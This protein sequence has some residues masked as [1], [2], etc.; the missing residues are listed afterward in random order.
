MRKVPE[1]STPIINKILE[2]LAVMRLSTYEFNV[3]FAII[4]KTY[5]WEKSEDWISLSQFE[6]ITEIP[7]PHVSR[8]LKKLLEKKIT[9]RNGSVWGMNKNTEEWVLPEQVKKLPKQVT[10]K[11]LTQTGKSD[12]PEQVTSITQTGKSDLPK[13]VNTKETITKE[14]NTKDTMTKEIVEKTSFSTPNDAEKDFKKNEPQKSKMK[15]VQ[16][17]REFIK[18]VGK[19]DAQYEQYIL[20]ISQKKN[21]PV[22]VVK[23]QIEK[24][25]DTWTEIARDGKTQKWERQETFELGL[26][27]KTWWQNY[28]K[29]NSPEKKQRFRTIS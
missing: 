26:R 14:T 18:M 10:S 1:R 24:F 13:Q 21:L 4:R 6:E 5:G 12:L 2:K 25:V 8:T 11:P 9:K 3:I 17:M 29:W 23:F 19:K 15:P 7:I 28:F 22:S 20:K 27:L 16:V